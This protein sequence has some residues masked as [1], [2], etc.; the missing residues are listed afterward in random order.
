[1]WKYKEQYKDQIVNVNG[2]GT[3]DTRKVDADLVGKLSLTYPKLVK[4]LEKVEVKKVVEVQTD[5]KENKK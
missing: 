2:Y 5:A 3:I 1:M 4:L